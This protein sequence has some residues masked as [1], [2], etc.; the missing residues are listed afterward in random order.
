MKNNIIA[1]DTDINIWTIEAIKEYAKS[2]MPF[3][4]QNFLIIDNDSNIRIYNRIINLLST[5]YNDIIKDIA[6]DKNVN[7]FIAPLTD[8]YDLTYF[9][10]YCKINN[11]S[12][13]YKMD[14][15]NKINLYF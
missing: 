15:D 3:Y 1:S 10:E 12:Y 8:R 4:K 14:E 9:E 6:N 5:S 13:N 7:L 11:I 2:G